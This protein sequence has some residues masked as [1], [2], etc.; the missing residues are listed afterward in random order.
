MTRIYLP[1]F[2]VAAFLIVACGD[3]STDNS[4]RVAEDDSSCTTKELKDKSGVKVIC[5][6]DS[7][8]VVLYGKNGKDGKDGADGKS[9]YEL[10]G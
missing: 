2:F 8:G 10:S 1:V 7:V 4:T 3:S 5:D 9:A 6:G